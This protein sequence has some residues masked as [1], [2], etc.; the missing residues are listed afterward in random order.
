MYI[1][2]T[3]IKQKHILKQSAIKTTN[4]LASVL[5]YTTHWPRWRPML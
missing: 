5:F 1:I 2:I 3:I 4:K